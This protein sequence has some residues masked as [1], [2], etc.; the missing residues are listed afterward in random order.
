MVHLHISLRFWGGL[1]RYWKVLN[2]LVVSYIPLNLRVLVV[3]QSVYTAAVTRTCAKALSPLTF[4]IVKV[5]LL[6]NAAYLLGSYDEVQ[7]IVS[8]FQML[9]NVWMTSCS[10]ARTSF[11]SASTLAARTIAN[12]IWACTLLTGNAEVIWW[13]LTQ[14]L[15]CCSKIYQSLEDVSSNTKSL[16]SEI[17]FNKHLLEPLNTDKQLTEWHNFLL[18]Q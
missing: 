3:K 17:A 8:F 2:S 13:F 18:A 11:T 7:M 12:V 4:L 9:T 16:P 14:W 5:F 15:N 6:R 10:I 1:F